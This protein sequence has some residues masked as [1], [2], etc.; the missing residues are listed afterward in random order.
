MSSMAVEG[1]VGSVEMGDLNKRINTCTCKVM[2]D[3]CIV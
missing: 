1:M 2:W 3:V